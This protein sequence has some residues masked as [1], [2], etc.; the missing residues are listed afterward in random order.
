MFLVAI[1][2]VTRK[3]LIVDPKTMDSMYLIGIA[4]L[5]AALGWAYV[6]TKRSRI[7]D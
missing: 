5:V 1:T 6:H 3:I 2:A 7:S 4:L